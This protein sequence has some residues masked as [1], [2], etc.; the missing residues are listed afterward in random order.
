[1][2]LAAVYE[3]TDL[4]KSKTKPKEFIRVWTERDAEHALRYLQGQD[5]GK[6]YLHEC[7][8]DIYD[9][10][11]DTLKTKI[12]KAKQIRLYFDR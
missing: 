3:Q 6:V 4:S 5:D 10:Q 11:P 7:T 8:V 1:M 2:D 9:K 12:V